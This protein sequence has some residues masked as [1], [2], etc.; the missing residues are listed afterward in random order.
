MDSSPASRYFL[1]PEETSQRHYEALR[2]IFVAGEPLGRVAERFGYKISALKSM[3]S[4]FRSACRRGVAPPFFY[5][6]AAGVPAGRPSV[7]T[8]RAASRRRSPTPGG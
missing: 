1:E 3:A 2:A 6:T 4:R 7:R 8:D 5:P